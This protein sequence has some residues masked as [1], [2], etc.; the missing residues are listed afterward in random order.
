MPSTRTR[1]DLARV[2]LDLGDH[3]INELDGKPRLIQDSSHQGVLLIAMRHGS[4]L[5]EASDERVAQ[6]ILN[7]HAFAL[8]VGL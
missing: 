2:E 1:H 8:E 6:E 7:I 4:F 3:E 5:R